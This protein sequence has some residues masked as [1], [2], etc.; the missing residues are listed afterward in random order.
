MKPTTLE[1][2][3]ADQLFKITKSDDNF[4]NY[5]LDCNSDYC[6]SV[7]QRNIKDNN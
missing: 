1:N 3:I 7:L 4:R 5:M 6:N 2:Q